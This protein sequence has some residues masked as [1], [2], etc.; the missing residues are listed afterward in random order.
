M[1]WFLQ[2]ALTPGFFN[3]K[4]QTLLQATVN[5]K[6]ALRWILIFVVL[7]NLEIHENY[8]PTINNDFPVIAEFAFQLPALFF[9][10]M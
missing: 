4:F 10:H 2:N 8:N 7:E 3:S 5:G 9:K 1:V 6:F